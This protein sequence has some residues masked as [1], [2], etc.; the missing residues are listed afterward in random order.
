MYRGLSKDTLRTDVGRVL[1]VQ[2][3]ENELSVASMETHEKRKREQTTHTHGR[4]TRSGAHLVHAEAEGSKCVR[5]LQKD[6][7]RTDVGKVPDTQRSK[8]GWVK[9]G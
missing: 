5:S 6:T 2:H 9:A 8:I 1:V 4:G 3:A 7:L